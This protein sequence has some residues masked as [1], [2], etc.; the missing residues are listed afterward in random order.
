MAGTPDLI[1]F[2][3]RHTIIFRR[4]LN[5]RLKDFQLTPP[6]KSAR[7]TMDGTA[8]QFFSERFMGHS[9]RVDKQPCC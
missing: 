5:V 3:L 8:G 2:S 1:L 6:V 9:P 7:R 4:L